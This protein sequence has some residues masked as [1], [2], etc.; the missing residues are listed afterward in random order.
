MA[1]RA[2]LTGASGFL[3]RHIAARLGAEGW[4]VARLGRAPAP[5]TLVRPVWDGAVFAEILAETAPDVVFHLAGSAWATP[6]SALYE[7]NL[8]LAARLLDAVAAR[9]TPP[10]VVLIGSAAELGFVPADAQPVTEDFP[11]APTT[12]HG[13]AKLAQ[14]RLGQAWARAGLK[15]LV[16]RLFNPVGAGMPAGLAL[17]SFAAQIRAADRVLRVGNLDVARDFIDVAEAARLIVA[18]AGD[19][20][21]LGQT[22]NICSGVATRLRPLVEAMIRLS[23]RDIAIEVDPARVRPGEMRVLTGS[24]ARLRAAGLVPEAPDFARVLPALLAG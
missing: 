5:G 14:T 20:A 19:P 8:M 1:R 17:P 12:H 4:A 2:L 10:A 3:G 23:G 6:V 22:V 11:C 24:I 18:L 13:I 21:R 9:A 16:A 15:V 7:T